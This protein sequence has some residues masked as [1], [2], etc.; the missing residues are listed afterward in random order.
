MKIRLKYED[1]NMGNFERIF[2]II[3]NEKVFCFKV[4]FDKFI[5]H[6]WR[7]NDKFQW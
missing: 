4:Y 5:E 7:W 6:C 2:P 1:R 3:D